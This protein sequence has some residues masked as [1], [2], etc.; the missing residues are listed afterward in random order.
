MEVAGRHHDVLIREHG[1]IIGHGVDFG[2][3]HI[4]HMLDGILAGAVH[5]RDTAEGVWVLNMLLMAFDNLR[6][7]KELKHVGG[8][9]NL[10]G[11]RTHHVY[12]EVERLDAT[13][14]SIQGYGGD[15]VGHPG[16]F[17]GLDEQPHGIRAHELGA[18]EQRQTLFGLQGD[19]FPAE[20]LVD[21]GSGVFLASVVNLAHADDRQAEVCL[22]RPSQSFA[23][24]KR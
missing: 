4:L 9:D 12:I 22:I 5:L 8:R 17:L 15:D 21:D 1:G 24:G 7:F 13:I 2:L 19:G 20:L 6:T 23:S 3:H 11:V 16:E 10:A 18:V 14:E